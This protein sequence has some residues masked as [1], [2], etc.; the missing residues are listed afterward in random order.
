MSEKT[1][2][3]AFSKAALKRLKKT[4]TSVRLRILEHLNQLS[5]LDDPL[6]HRDVRSLSGKLEGVYRLRVGKYRVILEVDTASKSIKV[7]LV[8]P[9]GSAY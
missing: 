2:S 3:V 1:W 6:R 4:E 9:R 5:V 8:E 7:M